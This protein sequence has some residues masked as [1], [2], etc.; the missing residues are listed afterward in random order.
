MTVALSQTRVRPDDGSYDV[1]AVIIGYPGAS[2]TIRIQF[3]SGD[4]QDIVF[5]GPRLN[6]LRNGVSQFA[7]LRLALE[8]YL[9]ATEP[10]LGGNAT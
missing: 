10:S 7:G 6:A 1:V 8:Q 4:T 2:V 9:A 5:S 3:G